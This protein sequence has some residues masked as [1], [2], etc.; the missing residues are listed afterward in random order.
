MSEPGSE[1]RTVEI[2]RDRAPIIQWCFRAYATGNYTI[3]SLLREATARGLTTRPGPKRPAGPLARSALAK[4][5]NN[6]YYCGVIVYKGA[7]YPGRHEPLISR[8]LFDRVQETLKANMNGEKVQSHPHYL[9][10]SIYCTRCLSRYSMTYANGNGGIYPYL[11]C[12][13]RQAGN[14]CDQ[15]YLPVGDVEENVAMFYASQQLSAEVAEEEADWL[16]G[17]LLL[18]RALLLRAA[19]QGMTPSEVA[20]AGDVLTSL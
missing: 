16:G 1:I 12:L 6:P 4:I 14:G 5:L 15:P 8:E 18:P 3:T 17:C 20:A 13:G 7:Q 19:Y 9:K 2:D 10:G 11:F